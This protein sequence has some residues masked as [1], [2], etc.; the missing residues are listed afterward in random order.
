MKPTVLTA[1]A[2]HPAAMAVAGYICRSAT[3]GAATQKRG[4]GWAWEWEQERRT[5]KNSSHLPS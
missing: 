5:R 4:D 2:T 3:T 1:P